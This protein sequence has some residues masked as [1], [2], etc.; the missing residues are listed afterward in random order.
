ME[1]ENT[2]TRAIDHFGRSSQEWQAVEE[3]GELLAALNHVHR[4]KDAIEHIAEEIADVEVC[5]DQLKIM[6]GIADKVKFFRDAKIA[7]LST[8]IDREVP[9]EKR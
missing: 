5:L 7:R 1:D 3:I 2:L 8:R 9:R 4:G 6:Y